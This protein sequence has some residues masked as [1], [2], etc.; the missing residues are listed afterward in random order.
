MLINKKIR[1]FLFINLFFIFNSNS[2]NWL[3]RLKEKNFSDFKTGLKSSILTSIHA[4]GYFRDQD[5]YTR[6][7]YYGRIDNGV[8]S[9]FEDAGPGFWDRLRSSRFE[10]DG[11]VSD[12]ILRSISSENDKTSRSLRN[13]FRREP[14]N[15]SVRESILSRIQKIKG[16]SWPERF[17]AGTK[18]GLSYG[19]I[20][21]GLGF[22]IAALGAY[23]NSGDPEAFKAFYRLFIPSVT[24]A[25]LVAKYGPGK[26]FKKSLFVNSAILASSILFTGI[27][28]GLAKSIW[29]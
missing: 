28:K 25:Y 1:I 10:Y 27:K 6:D 8:E 22:S 19:V 20:G 13:L 21:A 7:D 24:S 29:R 9:Y 14:I 15:S 3:N 16:M 2:I 23:A 11:I 17:K 12:G 4:G 5:G 18:W 26:G